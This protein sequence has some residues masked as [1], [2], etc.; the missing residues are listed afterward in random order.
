[1]SYLRGN[2]YTYS[3]DTHM[4]LPN[5]MPLDVFDALVMMR[6]YELGKTEKKKAEKLA[7]EISGGNFGCD[8]LAEKIGKETAT[9]QIEKNI[10]EDK[11]SHKPACKNDGGK[12]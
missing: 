12:E 7:Y 1:M 9:E 10:K 5:S 4:H 8:A 2:F 3:D 6:F 11:R